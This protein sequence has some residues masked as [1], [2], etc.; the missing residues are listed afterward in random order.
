MSSS[1]SVSPTELLE[2]VIAE[3]RGRGPDDLMSRTAIAAVGLAAGSSIEDRQ[4]IEMKE[5]GLGG[6]MSTKP[7]N[8]SL[9]RLLV[10]LGEGT[11][12]VAGAVAMNPWF[13]LLGTWVA[14][15][16]IYD[17]F[18]LKLDEVQA[19]LVW[20]VWTRQE[21]K[22][23]VARKELVA[24]VNAERHEFQEK[25]VS[26]DAVDAAVKALTDGGCIEIS[27]D[28]VRVRERVWIEHA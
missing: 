11:L 9:T 7:G 10:T 2:D 5:G 12:T 1:E 4:L 20:T 8:A 21:R 6:A 27:N 18:E 14:L 23:T 3:L 25:P 26:E 15:N 16:R 24:L 19:C 28:T 22:E 13:V 17:N